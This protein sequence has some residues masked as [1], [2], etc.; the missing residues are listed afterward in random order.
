[1]NIPEAKLQSIQ[2]Q[3][4]SK[5]H[6]DTAEDEVADWLEEKHGI[7]GEL[8]T[9]MITQ[10]LRKRRKEIRER[11]FY[12]LIFSAVGMSIP[13]SY[14]AMQWMTRRISLF[15]TPIAAVVFLICFASFLRALSRLLSGQTDAPIDP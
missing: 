9:S 8:A 6:W 5:I 7:A 12:L 11:A 1:M 15:L 4:N 3:V 14:L 10:A 13:G 2:D